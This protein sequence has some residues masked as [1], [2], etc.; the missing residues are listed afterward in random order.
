VWRAALTALRQ[1][2]GQLCTTAEALR[3]V[4]AR[5]AAREDEDVMG[6]E[7]E[8]AGLPETTR[9][10]L[11]GS[12]CADLQ[13]LE[14]LTEKLKQMSDYEHRRAGVGGRRLLLVVLLPL[15]AVGSLVLAAPA[16]AQER[17][18]RVQP[19]TVRL[20]SIATGYQRGGRLG[21]ALR[22]TVLDEVLYRRAPGAEPGL[23]WS[24]RFV[25]RWALTDDQLD[26]WS[27]QVIGLLTDELGGDARLGGWERLAASDVGERR[28]AYRYA[29]VS[30][31]G[32]PVGEATVVV[33]CRGDEVGLSSVA[34][35]GTSSPIDGVALARLMD[36]QGDHG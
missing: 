11:Y 33:F 18:P 6:L 29:L 5:P 14:D 22:D 20:E 32:R 4:L 19:A 7:W 27:A 35:L 16:A 10:A 25:S 15:L 8:A 9:V 21:F 3:A 17:A 31:S 28:V 12:I 24:A 26:R 23:L 36:P 34:A 1:F 13:M 2:H 30:S